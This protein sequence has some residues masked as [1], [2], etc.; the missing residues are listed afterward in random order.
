MTQA[1]T[2]SAAPL[3]NSALAICLDHPA[4]RAL[5]HADRDRAPADDL[6]VAAFER[7]QPEV[8]DPEPVVVAERRVPELEVG[9]G[10]QGM[11]PVD[12]GHVVGLAPAGRPVHGVDRDPAVDPARRVAREQAVGQRRQHERGRVVDGGRDQRRVLE[13][14][15]VQPR[16]RDRQAADQV[17]RQQL[18]AEAGQALVDGFRQARPDDH[19][20]PDEVDQPAP[21][22]RC[23]PRA[24]P[25]AGPARSGPRRPARACARRTG[26]APTAPAR[27]TGRR[28]TAARRGCRG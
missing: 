8:L 14:G 6:D 28:R 3:A 11:R 17:P 1:I 22:V 27:P 4:G 10:E 15:H 25:S 20:R 7:G 9:A 26:R 19:R 16:L 2:R 12:R 23:S 18:R 5:G 13:P 24:P 21:G